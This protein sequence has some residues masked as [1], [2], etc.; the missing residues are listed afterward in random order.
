MSEMMWG[1]RFKKAE[2]KI[3]LDLKAYFYY[4]CRKYKEYISR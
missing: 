4:D 3:A 2:E 1:G